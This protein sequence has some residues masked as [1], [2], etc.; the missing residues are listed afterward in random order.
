LESRDPIETLEHEGV[1]RVAPKEGET[2]SKPASS[3]LRIKVSSLLT[4]SQALADVQ[5]RP[6][7][8]PSHE[9]SSLSPP[10]PLTLK[11]G[12]PPSAP[13]TSRPSKAE[14]AAYSS[15]EDD[16]AGPSVPQAKPAKPKKP[17]LSRA[18]KR[19]LDETAALEP[20]VGQAAGRKSYDWL[21]PSF[22]G[23]SHAGPA[24]RDMAEPAKKVPKLS[25]YNEPEEQPMVL[26]TEPAQEKESKRSHKKKRDS[27]VVGPG[28]AWRKGIKKCVISETL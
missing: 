3:G 1:E 4:I 26:K 11:F 27:D 23:A 20:P 13:S 25:E 19:Q 18:K 28:K 14:R 12:L 5:L 7:R 17:R 22:A 9:R 15:S 16:E 6:A 24:G 8:P 21:I 10:P 2:S